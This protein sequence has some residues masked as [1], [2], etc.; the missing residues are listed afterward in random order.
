MFIFK[1]LLNKL[2]NDSLYRNAIWLMAGT[3]VMSG[4][5]VFYWIIATRLYSP[6]EIGLATTF[7]SIISLITGLSMLGFNI[8]LIRFLPNSKEKE[9]NINTA[10]SVVFLASL[11]FGTIFLIALPD[12]SDKLLFVRSSIPIVV[13]LIIF[14]PLNTLNGLTD[15]VFIAMRESKFVFVSNLSQSLTK[16]LVLVLLSSLGVWGLIGS[17]M[18]SAVV[19]VIICLVLISYRYKINLKIG[20]DRKILE[21]VRSYAL[22]NYISG[23]IGTLPTYLLPII[24][25]NRISPEQTAYF[26][27]P[28]MITGLLV[29]IPS[30]IAR[31]YLTE[32][33]H[34]DEVLSI[35][36]P[37]FNTFQLLFPLI[38]LI[39]VLGRFIL[40]I[41]GKIYAIESY[42]Y[43][44]I[45]SI[46]ILIS[47]FNYLLGSRLLVQHQTRK[48]IIANILGASS[49]IIVSF[50]LIKFGILGIAWAGVISQII[51][52]I[53]YVINYT[54]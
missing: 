42:F 13:M 28:N 46:S 10:F 18:A 38:F 2:K 36:K 35:K 7:I 20:I 49:T 23:F 50:I 16:I 25:T 26:Y 44:V 51:T 3:F 37:I 27:I 12:W 22:G 17:V 41:F 54:S 1:K 21:K 43:L 48:I 32:S 5:G 19:A 39:V 52:C 40:S 8:T 34:S 53:F 24:I 29:M 14:F 47:V 4:I 45:S 6:K 9:K 11:I 15:S 30:T 31:S 33:S